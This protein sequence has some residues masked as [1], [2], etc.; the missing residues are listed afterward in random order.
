MRRMTIPMRCR[1]YPAQADL[2]LTAGEPIRRIIRIAAELPSILSRRNRAK[3]FW[4]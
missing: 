4:V 3:F 2:R 1:T